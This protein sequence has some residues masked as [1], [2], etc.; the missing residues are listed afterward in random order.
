MTIAE[1][2]EL[3]VAISLTMLT[4]LLTVYVLGIVTLVIMLAQ[5]V[6]KDKDDG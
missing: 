6:R 5:D 3:M 4:I 2:L 1:Y